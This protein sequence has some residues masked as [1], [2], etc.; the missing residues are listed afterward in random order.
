MAN[1]STNSEAD[2]P[3]LRKKF[4][5]AT[6]AILQQTE[7]PQIEFLTCYGEFKIAC[8]ALRKGLEVAVPKVSLELGEAYSLEGSALPS[9]ATFLFLALS[10]YRKRRGVE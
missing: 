8:D 1:I 4:M 10:E 9:Y 7:R 3:E 6:Q 2:L 5:E